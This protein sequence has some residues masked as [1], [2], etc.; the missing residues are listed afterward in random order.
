MLLRDTN[1]RLATAPQQ[2]INTPGYQSEFMRAP[3]V[4][5]SNVY[6]YAKK[7]D[8]HEEG[9]TVAETSSTTNEP[10][11]YRIGKWRK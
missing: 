3:K 6:I 1:S 8:L 10:V 5:A 7:Y 11:Q 2:N 4:A 9:T